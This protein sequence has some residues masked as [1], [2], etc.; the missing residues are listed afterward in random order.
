MTITDDEGETIKATLNED[1]IEKDRQLAGYNML[2]TSE[3]NMSDEE[4]YNAYHN[5]WRIEE[6][7]R[8]MKSELDA[9]PAFVQKEDTIKGHFFIC[10]ATVLLERILQFKIFDSKFSSNEIY[11]FM[12]SFKVVKERKGR[13]I[14]IATKTDFIE[15]LRAKLNH[16]IT[17]FYL[18]EK[19]IS[20]MHTR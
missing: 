5:L 1:A 6:S 19:Q 15:A 13:Y 9:R 4:I 3:I 14:N 11:D 8:N 10:Y 12:K 16:P 20:L 7:F 17:N 18:T 2:V